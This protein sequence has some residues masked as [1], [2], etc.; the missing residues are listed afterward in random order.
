ML[1]KNLKM[2]IFPPTKY[3]VSF[4]IPIYYERQKLGK[5]GFKRS[6]RTEKAQKTFLR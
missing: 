3:L 1:D 5:E 6:Q 2:E 4:K